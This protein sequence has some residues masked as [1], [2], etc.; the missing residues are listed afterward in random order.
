MCACVELS[1]FVVITACANI[2]KH[3]GDA[4]TKEIE[5]Y[6][7]NYRFANP[8]LELNSIERCKMNS[9]MVKQEAK[10]EQSKSKKKLKI[11]KFF[12]SIVAKMSPTKLAVD[13][14]P[15]KKNGFT[16]PVE[17]DIEEIRVNSIDPWQSVSSVEFENASSVAEELPASNRQ[18]VVPPPLL[19]SPNPNHSAPYGLLQTNKNSMAVSNVGV[20]NN[21]NF[22]RIN[23]LHIGNVNVHQAKAA[24]NGISNGGNS[25]SEQGAE[26]S[27]STQKIPKTKSISGKRY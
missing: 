19:I 11:P 15:V 21:Y 20:Q 17:S 24:T 10:A 5:V 22:S 7:S 3:R 26:A 6:L 1:S 9:V 27:K 23:G 16:A 25:A 13:A 8:K 2:N 12:N 18:L 14:V 4:E